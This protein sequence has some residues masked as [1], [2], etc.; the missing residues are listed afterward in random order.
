MGLPAHVT[1]S[2]RMRRCH[3]REGI[4]HYW[5]SRTEALVYHTPIIAAVAHTVIIIY[6][7]VCFFPLT[8]PP[9]ILGVV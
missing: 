4:C 2:P 3:E 1:L 5:V 7:G 9:S 8:N 6:F